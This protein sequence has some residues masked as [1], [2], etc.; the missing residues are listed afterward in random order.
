MALSVPTACSTEPKKFIGKGMLPPR[1]L[2]SVDQNIILCVKKRILY[3][4]PGGLHFIAV[5][6]SPLNSFPPRISVTTATRFSPPAQKAHKSCDQLRRQIIDTKEPDILQSINR[7]DFPAPDIP[8]TTKTPLF[9]HPSELSDQ[10][11][12]ARQETPSPAKR[13]PGSRQL[14]YEHP[15]WSRRRNSR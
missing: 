2:I 11:D 13:F 14:A 8:V 15:H 1:F 4:S 9:S 3:D 10:T 7:P 5:L 12:L 6:T